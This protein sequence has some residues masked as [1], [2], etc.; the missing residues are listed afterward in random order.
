MGGVVVSRVAALR[1]PRFRVLL[2]SQTAA[3]MG[4]QMLAVAITVAVVDAGGDAVALGLVLA[5]RGIT[6]VAFLP[7]GG[8]WADRLQRRR[9]MTGAYAAQGLVA[10]TLAVPAVLPVGAAAAAVFVLGIAEA[11]VRPA[12]NGLLRGVLADEERVSGRS[13]VS[14]SI[15][16]GIMVG[17]VVCV[18]V[19]A[20]FGTQAAYVITLVVF[21][22]AAL[23]FWRVAEPRREPAP[24]ASFAADIRAGVAE[25]GSRPWV[26]AILVFSA[27][28]LMFVLAPTQVLLPIVSTAEF[29]SPAVYG[30][31]LT[32]YGVGGLVGGLLTMAWR[33]RWPGAVALA[34]MALY[35]A[36]PASLILSTEAWPVFVAY[37]VAG[38]GVE[39]YAIHW[40]VALQREI[41][42]HL[43]G[44]ISSFAWLCS[45]GLS[46]F[47]QALTGPLAELTSPATVLGAAAA[48]ILVLPPAL[49]L[50]K[51]MPYFRTQA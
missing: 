40:E 1:N 47:G 17:P 46:P 25:A 16:T 7:A 49:L 11:F 14:V 34:A 9:L 37:A 42:D 35:A 28:N 6:L 26:R 29:G 12:F 36:A 22:A 33:P 19:I 48:L 10:G 8:V 50:V 32:C 23:A 51:G 30:V 38:A 5:V 45:F 41:P 44:R 27:V 3:V 13:L 21:A 18:A 43:I 24:R 15:R 20:A 4:E 39:I 2:A 31:A